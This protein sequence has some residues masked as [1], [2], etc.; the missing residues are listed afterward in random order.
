MFFELY[1]VRGDSMTP[2]FSPGDRLVAVIANRDNVVL[3]RGTV[4]IVRDPSSPAERYLKRI[5]GLP[6]EELDMSE[7]QL[8]IDGQHL[9]EPYLGGLP[10]SPGLYERSWKL[11][12]DQYFVMGDNRVHSTDSREFGPVSAE[13]IVSKVRLRWWPP[14]R[15]GWVRR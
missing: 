11:G 2:T 12:H 14:G 4:V 7:G 8:L 5:V 9:F 15:W 13:L 6:G 1:S 10:A 3:V